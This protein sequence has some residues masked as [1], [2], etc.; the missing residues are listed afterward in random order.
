VDDPEPTDDE[1]SG[2]GKDGR[3]KLFAKIAVGASWRHAMV[4]LELGKPMLGDEI[5]NFGD[6]IDAL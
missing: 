6:T 1:P 4:V 2:L 3:S 5:C